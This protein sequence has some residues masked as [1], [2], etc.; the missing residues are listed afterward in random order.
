MIDKLVSVIIPVYNVE[1]Y[2]K[3]AVLSIINQTYKNLE[4][5]IV[6]D[7]SNDN[8]YKILKELSKIDNRIKL[9]KNKNNLKIAKTLN[10][11]LSLANGE[12]IARMD[13]DDISAI[14]RIE[15]KVS[16]LEKHKE[17]YLVGCSM[18][19]IDENGK[20]I[21]QTIYYK[22]PNLL[23]KILPYSTPVPHIW[24]ARKI[25]YNKLGGYRDIPGVEDYDFL[26]RMTSSGLRYT[27]LESYFGYF[28]RIAR[29]G[30]TLNSLGIKQI[31]MHSYVFNLYKER[32]KNNNNDTFSFEKLN[33][34]IKT[35]NILNKLH[36][37]SLK[38][39]YKAIKLKNENRY[40]KMIPYLIFSLI[41]PYQIIYLIRRTIYRII[42][43]KYKK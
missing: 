22:D 27:N 33:K 9:Y 15:K 29:Q 2:I 7:C 11:C 6:D 36:S 20:I 25:L 13:G 19:V 35:N 5:I 21:G 34:I 3:E 30:N 28:V 43:W 32:L 26:L 12:Y 10:R 24:V 23:L 18:K 38:S 8:T 1:K 41:S 17:F 40:F 42:I 39:L 37:I 16:F 31:K 4:I 14:D